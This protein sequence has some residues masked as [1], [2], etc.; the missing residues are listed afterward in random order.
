MAPVMKME[1]VAPMME[2]EYCGNGDGDELSCVTGDEDEF[3]H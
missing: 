1:Y 3:G 2:M